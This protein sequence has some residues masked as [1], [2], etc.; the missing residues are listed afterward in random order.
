[1]GLSSLWSGLIEDSFQHL[2]SK[3]H[4]SPFHRG[5]STRRKGFSFRLLSRRQS[6]GV[7]YTI[8]RSKND[9]VTTTL[10]NQ[11]KLRKTANRPK[12]GSSQIWVLVEF[13]SLF[14]FDLPGDAKFEF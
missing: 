7:D 10:N 13:G 4:K 6:R 1:M 11:H 8:T 3:E 14:L 2:V 5:L 9:S 12:S